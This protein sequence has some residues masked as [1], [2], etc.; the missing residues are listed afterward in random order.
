MEIQANSS[1]S[2]SLQHVDSTE[3]ANP[4]HD[5]ESLKRMLTDQ[6][7]TPIEYNKAKTDAKQ[8][9]LSLSREA[10]R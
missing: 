10:E 6:I 2:K 4:N 1:F 5:S 8:F 3:L 7:L 9:A